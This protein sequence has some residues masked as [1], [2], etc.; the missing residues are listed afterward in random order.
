MN[1]TPEQMDELATRVADQFRQNPPA[2]LQQVT[3]GVT[4][5]VVQLP[6]EFYDGQ[7]RNR[8]DVTEIRNDMSEFRASMVEMRSDMTKMQG[9]IVA[10][11]TDMAEMR[12]DMTT[13]QGEIVA[14]R[15]DMAEMRADIRAV[16]QRMDDFMHQVDKRF[17][18]VDKRFNTMQWF[19]GLAFTLVV[20]LM[21]VY[22]FIT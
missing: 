6:Q 2:V 17:Q 13:M 19:M 20:L 21:S 7:A 10:I 4:P 8:E 22:E 12:S 14:I 1:L 3:G 18:Q 16:N 5:M 9:E 15:T 11:R